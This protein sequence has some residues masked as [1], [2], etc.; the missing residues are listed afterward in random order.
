MIDEI[1]RRL[2]WHNVKT[3]VEVVIHPAAEVVEGL[4]GSLTQSR[5]AEHETFKKPALRKRLLEMG[6]EA[7]GFEAL[8]PVSRQQ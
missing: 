7:V 8:K 1:V 2:P 5:L 3:A 6:V 4:F